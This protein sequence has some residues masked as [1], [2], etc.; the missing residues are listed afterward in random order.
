MD[1]VNQTRPHCV[2]QMGKTQSK[3]LAERHGRETVWEWH[4]MCELE[5]SVPVSEVLCSIPALGLWACITDCVTKELTG[6]NNS[7]ILVKCS[8]LLSIV[9]SVV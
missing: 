8:V 2:N 7:C 9:P 3:P 5:L 4:V 1:C 6:K